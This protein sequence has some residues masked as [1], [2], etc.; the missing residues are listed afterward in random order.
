MRY[1]YKEEYK[2]NEWQRKS[3][4]KK[5][6]DNY[7]CQICGSNQKMVHVHHH[8]YIEG[9]HLWEYPDETLITLCEDC[10]AKEH[11]FDNR[12]L[13]ETVEEARKIGVM[14]LEIIEAIKKLM[15]PLQTHIP[16][17]TKITP[18]SYKSIKYARQ[19]I[20]N[21]TITYPNLLDKKK[22]FLNR[23]EKY[24]VIYEPQYLQSFAEYWTGYVGGNKKTLRF[25][26]EDNFFIPTYLN[27]WK[28]KRQ[29]IDMYKKYKNIIS[30]AEEFADEQ[31]HQYISQSKKNIN[32][33]KTRIQSEIS[34]IKDYFFNAFKKREKELKEI[35]MNEIFLYSSSQKSVFDYITSK[36][37][38]AIF[39]LIYKV[40]NQENNSDNSI[41]IP[42]KGKKLHKDIDFSKIRLIESHLG[43]SIFKTLNY[44]Q[45]EKILMNYNDYV[46]RQ[47]RK[48]IQDCPYY[49]NLFEKESHSPIW[50]KKEVS[51]DDFSYI[52][53]ASYLIRKNAELNIKNIENLNDDILLKDICI[54]PRINASNYCNIS[55]KTY[56]KSIIDVWDPLTSFNAL[57]ID[58]E[59]GFIRILTNI[60]NLP[61]K[62]FEKLN[63][64]YGFSLPLYN[65]DRKGDT[66]NYSYDKYGIMGIDFRPTIEVLLATDQYEF[67]FCAERFYNGTMKTVELLDKDPKNLDCYL[68]K[69]QT[70]IDL[71]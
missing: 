44:N 6:L 14:G 49:I 55:L 26:N 18:A 54:D 7:T 41:I 57:K 27:N 20:T 15:I 46:E 70:I 13:F 65:I 16:E 4:N 34:T 56:L 9:R 36:N 45:K 60:K 29:E 64:Q 3:G 59:F 43:I 66:I 71:A 5:Q 17:G 62:L 8:Y 38:P 50:K 69:I 52:Y 39:S 68:N 22:D 61:I 48:Y 51:K 11:N 53:T 24:G 12:L 1:N 37:L 10:H 58:V 21:R 32:Q 47:K 33:N 2:T 63:Q 67:D 35:K 23:L 40:Q 25:E 30:N 19:N 31:Y 28:E 42:Y